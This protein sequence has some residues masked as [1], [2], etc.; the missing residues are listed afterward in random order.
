[1]GLCLKRLPQDWQARYAHPVWLAESFVDTQLFR[2]TAYKAS[3]WT[4]LGPTQ[5]YGRSQQDYY[6]K[7]DRPK[8]LFVKELK[9]NAGAACAPTAAAALAVVVES[10]CRCCSALRGGIALE[11]FDKQRLGP[12]MFHIVVLLAAAIALRRPQFGP[13]AG[14]IGRAPEQL[15][16][17]KTLR[18]P[19][20]MGVARLPILR[21]PLGT[22]YHPRRQIG[23][24]TVLKRTLWSP[25]PTRSLSQSTSPGDAEMLWRPAQNLARQPL[26]TRH[27]FDCG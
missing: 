25:A 20:R 18:Q 23:I 9:P 4:E 26:P 10:S 1:M 5:G 3:G 11:F 14:F 21:Q 22:A 7:H 6:V 27:V 2:G 13:A 15:G 17:H 8:A 16:V 19:H 12:V 24:M